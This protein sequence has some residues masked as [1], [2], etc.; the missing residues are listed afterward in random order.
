MTQ[1]VLETVCSFLR[2]SGIQEYGIRRV[3][4]NLSSMD[5]TQ[6]D[7]SRRILKCIRENDL[8]PVLSAW[9]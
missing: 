5:C 7:I 9:S 1:F 3:D 4:I 6:T 8:P 2:A